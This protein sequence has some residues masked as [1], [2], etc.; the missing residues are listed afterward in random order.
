MINNAKF[1]LSVIYI[2]IHFNLLKW[3][4]N[5]KYLLYMLFIKIKLD[6]KL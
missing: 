5:F 2:D 4:K 1:L 3:M 6:N